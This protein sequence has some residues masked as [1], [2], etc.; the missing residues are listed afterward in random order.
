MVVEVPTIMVV[1]HSAMLRRAVPVGCPRGDVCMLAQLEGH[2]SAIRFRRM[3][4]LII[5]AS[6]RIFG[7]Q[8]DTCSTRLLHAVLH[9]VM[10]TLV[11][12]VYLL[13]P[14][15]SVLLPKYIENSDVRDTLISIKASKML[16]MLLT[17]T[18]T[19]GQ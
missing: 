9:Q 7:M 10:G 6:S 1:I 19:L 14:Y 13:S 4:T 2:G 3:M 12:I 16:R 11:C 5:G 17:Q 15:F 8:A 18:K